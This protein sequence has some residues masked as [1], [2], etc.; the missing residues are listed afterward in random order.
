M[1]TNTELTIAYCDT[2]ESFP[3]R[4]ECWRWLCERCVYLRENSLIVTIEN[5]IEN[6]NQQAAGICCQGESTGDAA[7]KVLPI[8][9]RKVFINLLEAQPL[10]GQGYLSRLYEM[11]SVSHACAQRELEALSVGQKAM[12]A[13]TKFFGVSSEAI[14]LLKLLVTTAQI[15]FLCNGTK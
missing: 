15:A 4:S 1:L 6:A 3:R 7:D 13:E 2:R 5:E 11:D 10:P 8:K 9:R 14:D 12:E